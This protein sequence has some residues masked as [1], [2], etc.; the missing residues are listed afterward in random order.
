MKGLCPECETIHKAAET[1]PVNKVTGEPT[2]ERHR[3]TEIEVLVRCRHL[4]FHAIA[5]LLKDYG[6]H[7]AENTVGRLNELDVAVRNLENA[8]SVAI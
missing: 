7:D 2:N 5:I 4:N 1:C 8:K 6:F 3:L